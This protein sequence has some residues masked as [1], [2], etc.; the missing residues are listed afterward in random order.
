MASTQSIGAPA[1]S[2]SKVGQ[3]LAGGKSTR[4]PKLPKS[5]KGSGSGGGHKHGGGAGE[6]GAKKGKKKKPRGDEQVVEPGEG[7]KRAR[8][9]GTKVD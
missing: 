1:P 8:S 3:E 5:P 2:L 6:N 7:K 9:P 4:S